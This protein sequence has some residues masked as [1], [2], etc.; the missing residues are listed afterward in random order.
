MI[1]E[2]NIVEVNANNIDVIDSEDILDF[3]YERYKNLKVPDSIEFFEL[4]KIEYILSYLANERSFLNYLLCAVDILARK[5]K[6]AKLTD[7]H[8]LAVCKKEIIK[9]YKDSLETMSNT[10]SRMITIYQLEKE[11][12]RYEN[13]LNQIGA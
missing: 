12:E 8:T 6:M 11:Q 3:F 10:I 4:A 1:M 2:N 7:E 13:K 5:Y 9:A